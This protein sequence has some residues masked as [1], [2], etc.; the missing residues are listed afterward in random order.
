M[1]MV[2]NSWCIKHVIKVSCGDYLAAKLAAADAVVDAVSSATLPWQQAWQQELALVLPSQHL[3]G[4]SFFI[5]LF[6]VA[7]TF[8]ASIYWVIICQHA[9]HVIPYLSWHGIIL[10]SQKKPCKQG[11]FYGYPDDFKHL[12]SILWHLTRFIRRSACSAAIF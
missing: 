7:F 4:S 1:S 9:I 5:K 2:H 11:D 12:L 6:L 3:S 10:R 8:F